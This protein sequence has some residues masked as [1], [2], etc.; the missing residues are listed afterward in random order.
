MNYLA[1]LGWSHGDQE[2][3][4][5]EEMENLLSL[6]N[7]GKSAA[8]F[9]PDKLDWLNAHY[10]K[11]RPPREIAALLR[12]FLEG[13]GLRPP[14]DDILEKIVL[15]LRERSKTLRE[16]A[17]KARFYLTDSPDLD[18]A[19]ALKFLNEAGRAI[20]LRW[21]DLLGTKLNAP[22]DF[23]AILRALAEEL[24]IK[25]GA[26]AQPLRLALT[27][28]TASPPLGDIIDILGPEAVLKRITAA[29][30]S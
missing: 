20:L 3:F 18:P 12:P 2:I 6:K 7:I 5:L 27:G 16:M 17:E 24:G 8:V 25:A 29:L 13:L 21:R 26:A 4:T 10:I 11:A 28:G 15:T 23:E 30:A 1:R 19:A 14:E 9:N 22:S